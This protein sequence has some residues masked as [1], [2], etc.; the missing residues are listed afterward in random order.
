[1]ELNHPKY[2]ISSPIKK[3]NQSIPQS[4]RGSELKDVERGG[5]PMRLAGGNE[6][7]R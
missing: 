1:M 3:N 7:W 5:R 6:R 2:P 4:I